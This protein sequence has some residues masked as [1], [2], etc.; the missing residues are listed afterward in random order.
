MSKSNILSIFITTI[1]IKKR[2]VSTL[3]IVVLVQPKKEELC[4]IKNC[5]FKKFG[6]PDKVLPEKI[7][8]GFSGAGIS[9]IV[10]KTRIFYE[11][12]KPDTQKA[13]CFENDYS[14]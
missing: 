10:W 1:I 13:E 7:K 4:K 12:D 8:K 14:L 3:A 5:K 6:K 9:R 11:I 2:L